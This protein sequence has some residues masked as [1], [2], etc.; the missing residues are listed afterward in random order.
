MWR[1]ED[2]GGAGGV[3]TFICSSRG[4]P[5]ENLRL[6]ICSTFHIFWK[7]ALCNL[8]LLT[9][10]VAF[11]AR[12]VNAGDEGSGGEVWREGGGSSRADVQ[13]GYSP[14]LRLFHH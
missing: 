3:F 11:T 12:S 2:R 10:G 5:T 7:P 14:I 9:A 8:Q 13:N 6:E 4:G 1:E